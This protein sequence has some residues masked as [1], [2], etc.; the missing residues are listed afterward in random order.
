[1][2][3]PINLTDQQ[4]TE[5]E[6]N[7]SKLVLKFIPTI[8]R[9]NRVKK[10][11]DIRAFKQNVRQHYFHNLESSDSNTLSEGEDKIEISEA[12]KHKSKFDIPKADN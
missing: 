10:W 7:V 12:W 5:D 9:Y 1:M 8:K 4:L 11:I 6:I 3:N 2:F